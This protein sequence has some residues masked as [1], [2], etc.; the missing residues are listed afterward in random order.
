M[1]EAEQEQAEVEP[2]QTSG[3]EEAEDEEEE[4]GGSVGAAR[5]AH[6]GALF[7]P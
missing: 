4:G 6:R 7:G 3:D 5:Q 1:S 2:R